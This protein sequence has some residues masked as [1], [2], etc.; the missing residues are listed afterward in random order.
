MT[1]TTAEKAVFLALTLTH[2]AL[3][4]A[5]PY[6]PTQDGPS[7]VANAVILKDY[8]KADTRYHEFFDLAPGLYPNW[9]TQGLLLL[10]MY[11]VPPL[12]AEK[13]LVSFYII[14]FTWGYRYLVSAIA[15][16]QFA[17]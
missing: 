15:G 7:H 9:A 2:V 4:W 3:I 13:L 5:F 16:P 1:S 17:F 6:V 14:G 12:V 10:L 8:G 11:L